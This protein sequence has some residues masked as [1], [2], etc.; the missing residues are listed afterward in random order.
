MNKEP[1][2]DD[3]LKR[4]DPI[5]VMNRS[6]N[7]RGNVTITM[8][9]PDGHPFLV[10]VPKTWIPICVTDQVSHDAINNS[11]DFRRNLSNGMLKLLSVEDAMTQLKDPDSKAELTRLNVS[12]YS[13]YDTDI[14]S[15]KKQD[16]VEDFSKSLETVDTINLTVREILSRDIPTTEKYHL[17]RADEEILTPDDL[18]YIILH[19]DGKL[20]EWAEG[21]IA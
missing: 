14:S 16:T 3:L 8:F 10:V 15:L 5:Y 2:L 13:S 19:G 4:K 21:K 17:I 6:N 1:N 11:S 7:P 12:K 20:K 9:R 18:K